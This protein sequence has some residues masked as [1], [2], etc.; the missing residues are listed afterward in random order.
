[1]AKTMLF[2]AAALTAIRLTDGRRA[3]IPAGRAVPENIDSADARR[4]L[5]EGFLVEVEI[6]D[7][8]AALDPAELQPE[9]PTPPRS[10][11]PIPAGLTADDV[12]RAA[13]QERAATA[14]GQAGTAPDGV[15]ANGGADG[16]GLVVEGS[17]PTGEPFTEA[18]LE[19]T[20]KG[21][22]DA[23]LDVVGDDPVKAEQVLTAENAK[24]KPRSTLVA[25]LQDVL[26]A[27]AA[28]AE[29]EA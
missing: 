1:M 11:S 28:D 8:V 10:R 3:N 22:V 7:E 5:D 21:N 25:G 20:V 13:E 26:D 23:I 29:D 18:E 6:V 14:V 19:E 15:V 24:E 16:T 9:G 27:V 2:G 4:L 17:E 12:A